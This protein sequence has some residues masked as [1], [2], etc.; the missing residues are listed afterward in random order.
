[1]R[2]IFHLILATCAL[3]PGHALAE[4]VSTGR[5]TSVSTAATEPQADP[6]QVMVSTRL[7]G[8]VLRVGEAVDY[9]LLR[10][11]YRLADQASTDPNTNTLLALP[12]PEVHRQIGPMRL[13]DVLETLG[14]KAYV[15]VIDP[16]HRQV[17]FDL[18]TPYQPLL[19]QTAEVS[20]D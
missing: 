4:Q 15:L 18:K 7:P 20:H 19:I 13:R 9:L 2:S 17:S 3:I 8:Y 14:G 11:G 10:S 1:M 16:V 6:L 5:Y 12:L